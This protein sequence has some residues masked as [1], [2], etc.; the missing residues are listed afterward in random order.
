MDMDMMD[1]LVLVP[2]PGKSGAAGL[3][4]RRQR[5]GRQDGTLG[6]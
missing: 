1:S 6:S 4:F 3:Y 5:Q 2:R